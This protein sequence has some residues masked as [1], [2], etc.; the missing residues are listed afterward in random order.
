MADFKR[1][2][3]LNTVTGTVRVSVCEAC[4]DSLLKRINEGGGVVADK[5]VKIPEVLYNKV[6]DKAADDGISMAK[7]LDAI[8][9]GK[10]YPAVVEAFVPSC[11]EELGVK[12]PKDYRWIKALTEVLPSG[13]RGKL[14]PYAEVLDCAE[15]KAELKRLAE[16]HLDE[17]SEVSEEEAAE[18]A[19][20][21][22][23]AG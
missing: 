21:A 17:V 18:A 20:E 16:E 8:V 6:K 13:L 5:V 15:A 19:E 1:A 22:A 12:M 11:A 14:E 10:P 2:Y 9:V 23:V 3:Y 4:T 7:A